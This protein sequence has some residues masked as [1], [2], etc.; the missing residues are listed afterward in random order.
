MFI[1][2]FFINCFAVSIKNLMK[3]FRVQ[4]NKIVGRK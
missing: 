2:I 1:T 4:V 3:G